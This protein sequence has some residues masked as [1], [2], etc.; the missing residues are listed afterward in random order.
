M[1]IR[2][3]VMSSDNG[4]AHSTVLQ[5]LD[6]CPG[7]PCMSLSGG[8]FS[9]HFASHISPVSYTHLSLGVIFTLAV[10]FALV[11]A[12]LRYAEQ[13]LSLIHIYTT[14]CPYFG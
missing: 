7:S 11:R 4:F 12:G 10:L 2:D 5:H 14:C 3:R 8:I 1:C 6:L 13:S 9:R